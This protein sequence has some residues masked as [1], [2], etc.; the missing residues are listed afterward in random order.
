MPLDFYIV[1]LRDGTWQASSPKHDP[2][3]FD[4]HGPTMNDAIAQFMISNRE[5]L[6]ILFSFKR[7]NGDIKVSTVYG[8]GRG[9]D[10]LGPSERLIL[11]WKE[12][13]YD[14]IS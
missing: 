13:C 14:E 2:F 12:K 6:D 1:E 8:K 11:D 10:E 7:N 5:K 9:P 4:A 3:L